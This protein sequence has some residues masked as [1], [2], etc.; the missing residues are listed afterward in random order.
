MSRWPSLCT[1]VAILLI[2]WLKKSKSL[3]CVS[4]ARCTLLSRPGIVEKSE[5]LNNKCNFSFKITSLPAREISNN[6]AKMSFSLILLIV[7]II[8]F[9]YAAVGHGGASGYI[10]LMVLLGYGTGY[11]KPTALLLNMV[12]SGISFVHFYRSG[13]FRRELFSSFVILSIPMAYLGAKWSVGDYPHKVLLA[14]CLMASVAR[15]LF[16]RER[17]F[18]SAEKKPA[19]VLALLIGAVIGLISGMIGIGGGVLLSPVLLLF[20]WAD[21][22]ESAAVAALFILVNS[23]A[24]M[25]G[26]WS[27]DIVFSPDMVALVASATM[28]GFAGSYTGVKGSPLLLKY[29]LSAVMCIAIVKLLL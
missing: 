5:K 19:L 14:V 8:A 1:N 29:I 10:A 15:V 2:F 6:G 24:G 27:S 18:R 25:A 26:L 12:V 16:F 7:A 13:Y 23:V 22:K 3:R 20:R 11:I 4:N 9:L 28:G 17:D 21:L